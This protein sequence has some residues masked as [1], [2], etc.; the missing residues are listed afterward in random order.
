MYR[1]NHGKKA[2]KTMM[3]DDVVEIS[4]LHL[5][6]VQSELFEEI[7]RQMWIKL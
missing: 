7:D 1:W 6:I 2:R 4:S 3:T 5:K